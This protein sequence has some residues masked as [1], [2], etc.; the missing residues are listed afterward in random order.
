MMKVVKHRYH[1]VTLEILVGAAI[2]AGFG[3]VEAAPTAADPSAFSALSCSCQVKAPAGSR[4][5]S[6][7]IT[8]G[9]Q[10]GLADLSPGPPPELSAQTT[11]ARK[12]SAAAR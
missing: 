12:L 8:Q 5:R 6:D 2:A 10:Q 1:R 11:L 4:L 7:E 3:V 9:I